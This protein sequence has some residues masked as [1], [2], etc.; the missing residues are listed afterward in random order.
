MACFWLHQHET[1]VGIPETEEIANVTFYNIEVTVGS[2]SWHVSRRYSEF[3]EMHNQLIVNHGVVKDILPPKKV[4][5]NKCPIFIEIR[6]K[7]LEEYLQTV[8]MYLNRT[9]PK[10]FVE[11][12][13]F[14]V[15]DIFFLLQNLALQF[16]NE[17]DSVLSTTK[18]YTFNPL[19]V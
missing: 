11:F 8:L 4:I 5:R 18:S 9:M 13:D 2:V 6:R 12:L 19:Q 15:Y 16:F 3:F 1:S 17:A 14:H 7:G 10:I